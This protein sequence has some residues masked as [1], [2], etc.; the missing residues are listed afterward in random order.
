MFWAETCSILH[1]SL[2]SVI[3]KNLSYEATIPSECD[4]NSCAG[5]GSVCALRGRC[6]QP[7]S[8]RHTGETSPGASKATAHVGDS[9]CHP[10]LL[11]SGLVRVGRWP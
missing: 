3:L 7:K 1:L 8:F 10:G 11:L 9:L 2:S 6:L 4:R 5:K